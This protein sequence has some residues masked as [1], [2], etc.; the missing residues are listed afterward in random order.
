[1]GRRNSRKVQATGLVA[2]DWNEENPINMVL[3][4][5][6]RDM[7]MGAPDQF[8]SQFQ[9]N[10]ISFLP[11]DP[12]HI[13]LALDSYEHRA[14][15]DVYRVNIYD[16]KR[17]RIVRTRSGIRNWAAD[18][19]GAVRFG[20]GTSR[21]KEGRYIY[22]RSENNDWRELL[23]YDASLEGPAFIFA[24]FT[25]D[26]QF[27]YVSKKDES[28]RQAYYRY[29]VEAGKVLDK[30][31]GSDK[32]DVEK[33]DLDEDGHL[34][35]YL[36]TNVKPQTVYLDKTRKVI[37]NIFGKNFPDH[38]AYIVSASKDVTKVYRFGHLAA[39]SRRLLY[40]GSRQK[41]LELAGGKI[42]RPGP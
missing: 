2:V 20:F 36:H 37:A 34:R 14:M 5:K 40:S 31:A 41:I 30:I 27:I 24:G 22:R 12:D 28:G 39:K 4:Q 9:D 10:V 25:P 33:I 15:P 21:N 35:G 26:P 8:R 13:L 1:M 6:R 38:T 19:N 11:D 32:G 23:S 7:P 18:S 16:G 3:S 42:S 29:D 17:K